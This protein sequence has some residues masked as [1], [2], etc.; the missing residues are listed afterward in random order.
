MYHQV[1]SLFPFA[2]L[3]SLNLIGINSAQAQE[4]AV[5]MNFGSFD[6]AVA[7]AKQTKKPLVVFGMVDT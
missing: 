5:E 3:L 2:L 7:E 6:D 1:R 4:A